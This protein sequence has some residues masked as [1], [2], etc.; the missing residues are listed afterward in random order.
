MASEEGR[1]IDEREGVD[2]DEVGLDSVGRANTLALL[3]LLANPFGVTGESSTVND[4]LSRLV[5]LSQLP[6]W[7]ALVDNDDED[8]DVE[9]LRL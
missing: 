5:L 6:K 4:P 9:G 3:A 2:K 8:E 7:P 1:A